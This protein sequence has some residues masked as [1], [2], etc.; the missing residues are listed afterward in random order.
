[1]VPPNCG[2]QPDLAYIYL[3]APNF[4]KIL[5]KPYRLLM[6]KAYNRKHHGR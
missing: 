4:T 5:Q 2:V 3:T 6:F 1:M